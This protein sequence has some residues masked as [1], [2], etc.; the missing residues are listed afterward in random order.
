[1]PRPCTGPTADPC[2]LS[3][4][5]RPPAW[6]CWTPS[7]GEFDFRAGQQPP[8]GNLVRSAFHYF[9]LAVIRTQK[10]KYVHFILPPPLV[11]SAPG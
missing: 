8:A 5:T 3:F 7:T 2:S 9:N 4:A 11:S 10:W 1:M 6:R